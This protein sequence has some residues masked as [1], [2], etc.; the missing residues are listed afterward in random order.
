VKVCF[1]AVDQVGGVLDFCPVFSCISF[2]W[3]K[4]IQGIFVR[5]SAV[6]I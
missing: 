1:Q 6:R 2:C 5:A 4:R 3:W